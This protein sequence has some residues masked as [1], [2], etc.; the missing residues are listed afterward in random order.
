M[1]MANVIG[2]SCLLSLGVIDVKKNS[3]W[4]PFLIHTSGF[5]SLFSST[6]DMM[7]EDLL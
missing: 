1:F 5:T 3:S 6:T 7:S 2:V 4:I